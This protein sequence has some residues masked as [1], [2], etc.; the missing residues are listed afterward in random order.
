MLRGPSIDE[1]ATQFPCELQAF[2]HA[3]FGQR[4]INGT[5]TGFVGTYY[6]KTGTRMTK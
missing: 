1:C 2:C 5:I 6:E 3:E 4:T